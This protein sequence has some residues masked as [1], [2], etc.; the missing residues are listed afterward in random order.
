MS[1]INNNKNRNIL[2][3]AAYFTAN[4]KDPEYKCI[5]YTL[6]ENN[7]LQRSV[8]ADNVVIRSRGF[9][10][11][12]IHDPA[13]RHFLENLTTKILHVDMDGGETKRIDLQKLLT[14]ANDSD[15]LFHAKNKKMYASS[16]FYAP[17]HPTVEDQ[18]ELARR[19]SHSLS[20]AK[21]MKSK[22]QSMYVNRK[23]RSVKWIHDGNG[24]E[25]GD[26]PESISMICKDK[27]PLKCV[28]NPNGKVLDIHG[29]QALGEEVNIEETPS[30]PEKLFDIVRD[31]NN[32]KGRG[33]EIFAKRRKRSEKWVVEKDQ[34]QTITAPFTPKFKQEADVK[35]NSALPML[36][37]LLIPGSLDN[38]VKATT[39]TTCQPFYNPF[40][41]DLSLSPETTLAPARGKYGNRYV[42]FQRDV[43][44][45][46]GTRLEETKNIQ[47]HAMDSTELNTVNRR[48]KKDTAKPKKNF[49]IKRKTVEHPAGFKN[50]RSP[51][52]R[53]KY[54]YASRGTPYHDSY[55]GEMIFTPG[56][57]TNPRQHVGYKECGINNM[58]SKNNTADGQSGRNEYDQCENGANNEY[59]PIPVKQLIKEFE[60]TCRP[61]MHYKQNCPNKI[62][63][64]MG[65]FDNEMISRYFE[66]RTY[67]STIK[68]NEDIERLSHWN[69][70]CRQDGSVNGCIPVMK[71][72]EWTSDQNYGDDAA[73]GSYIN[74]SPGIS[75]NDSVSENSRQRGWRLKYIDDDD[76]ST[77]DDSSSTDAS[78]STTQSICTFEENEAYERQGE[79]IVSEFCDSGSCC[80]RANGRPQKPSDTTPASL[81]PAD[82]NDNP[83]VLAMVASEE[84][85]LQTIKQLRRTPVLQNLIPT[86]AS[87]E[88]CPFSDI[89]PDVGD[90]AHENTEYRGPKLNSYQRLSNYNTAPRGWDQAHTYYRPITFGR[91]QESIVYSDF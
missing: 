63:T 43:G 72:E 56:L 90:N 18:V 89:S 16:Y 69:E 80:V 37:P 62:A 29:I 85:I 55:N 54:F 59:T 44:S 27:I 13:K 4:V 12:D 71:E 1:Y 5:N 25:S 70:T 82:T 32:Q 68:R 22:G 45:Y 6:R 50:S 40:T 65:N 24:V 10:P 67:V 49:A 42:Q 91:P 2:S 61:V 8:S 33:A 3:K 75:L 53:T 28:M 14:P 9:K 60:K 84:D 66:G 23:K 86:G 79:L 81:V 41:L 20:D 36:D 77:T 76:T 26:E 47:V 74:V 15:E 46:N 11:S 7:C 21:N 39:N 78:E 83:L 52:N 64:Q 58:N 57:K 19:I 17:S 88:L 38:T 48:E 30:H 73:P 51:A 35:E 34:S 31:L 87:P